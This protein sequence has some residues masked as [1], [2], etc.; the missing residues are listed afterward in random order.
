MQILRL[1]YVR[2]DNGAP[3]S[4][5]PQQEREKTPFI[6]NKFNR[7][8]MCECLR[9]V[10]TRICCKICCANSGSFVSPSGN[11]MLCVANG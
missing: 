7:A 4:R 11:M 8:R 3:H 5:A 6:V 2:L 9:H 10:R 1:R